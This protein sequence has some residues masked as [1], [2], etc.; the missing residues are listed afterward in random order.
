ME[1]KYFLIL[2]W[3]SVFMAILDSIAT[4]STPYYNLLEINPLF[5]NTG[6]FLFIDILNIIFYVFIY[7]LY[8]KSP[9]D[10]LKVALINVLVVLNIIRG[11]SIFNACKTIFFFKTGVITKEYIIQ[12]LDKN[13]NMIRQAQN[14][15]AMLELISVFVG[16]IAFSIWY[17]DNKNNEKI[18][19][20][21]NI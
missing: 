14:L 3:F 21:K 8:K 12:V 10:T 9:F 13:P 18:Y 7:F 11:I 1:N 20:N 16:T 2:F 17:K 19:K 15:N 5:R 4:L 6:T